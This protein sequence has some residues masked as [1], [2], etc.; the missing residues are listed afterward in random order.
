[1]TAHANTRIDFK[2]LRRKYDLVD[3]VRD[4][5]VALTQ[6]G[7]EWRACCPIHGETHPSFTLFPGS[8]SWVFKCFGCGRKG[9][10][11][12]FVAAMENVEASEAV[13]ILT[14]DAGNAG[15][16]FKPAA[17]PY[18]KPKVKQWTPILPVPEDAP[19]PAGPEDFGF[20][21]HRTYRTPVAVWPYLDAQG[22][23]LGYVCRFQKVDQQTG[24]VIGK[25]VL[26]FTFG[27][28]E[29]SPRP[30]WSWKAF[31]EPRPL[32]GLQRL[33]ARPNAQVLLVEGEKTADAAQRLLPGVVAVSWPGGGKAIAKADWTPLV[34]RKVCIWPDADSH[35]YTQADGPDKAGKMRPLDEQAG[36]MTA[37]KIALTLRAMSAPEGPAPYIK[38]VRLPDPREPQ[39]PADG[40]DLADAESEG[41]DTKRVTDYLKAH[42]ADAWELAAP[43]PATQH[44]SAP[45][46]ASAT[47]PQATQPEQRE[48][49]PTS[50]MDYAQGGGDYGQTMDA[51]D[52]ED[53]FALPFQCL[54]YSEGH[55]CFL[56]DAGTVE[57]ISAASMK[58]PTMFN[59]APYSWWLMNY[60]AKNG[61]A[62]VE[63]AD[64]LVKRSKVV[65][66][67]DPCRIRGRGA[68]EDAGRSVV[69]MGDHLIV[70]GLPVP[71]QT[72]KSRFIYV[73]RP[74]DGTV[75][76]APASSQDAHK[77]VQLCDMLSWERPIF[78]K[79]LAGWCAVAHVCG[80]LRW[81][82]HIWITG[83]SGSGKSS[84]YDNILRAALSGF[85]L[86]CQ[87][88]STE[89]G[90][91]QSLGSDAL[92][93]IF[94]E[95]ESD[96]MK[97]RER[98]RAIL[99]LARQASSEN[100]AAILKG[101]ANGNAQE[102]RIRSCFAFSSIV[103]AAEQ[104]ADVSRITVL[105]LRR[106]TAPDAEERFRKISGAWAELMTPAFAAG[107]RARCIR[108]IP[109]ILE[110]A[111]TF[112]QAVAVHLGSR[113]Y[114]DQVGALLAGAYA[115]HSDRAISLEDAKSWVAAQDWEQSQERPED[116]DE[117]RLLL[118]LL[119]QPVAIDP[120][121]GSGAPIRR[122]VGEV[123]RA[124][125]TGTA[126]P[127]WELDAGHDALGRMGIRMAP[128]KQTAQLCLVVS[129]SH[130]TLKRALESTPW[131]TGWG[132]LLARI[133]GADKLGTFRF[134][135]ATT[136]AVRIPIEATQLAEGQQE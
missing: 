29:G 82:P 110:N 77:L 48:D 2:E 126:E 106:Y 121:G 118:H 64:A 35:C 23:L 42:V 16:S 75:L 50:E 78:G 22:Q 84:V 32:Y 15:R 54:G 12:D 129:E 114:G 89:A 7:R 51:P 88:A 68:W 132:R 19:R 39:A 67:F 111:E 124:L 61:V 113:R 133:K 11:V 135:G 33:A 10:V 125:M 65:G 21:F 28:Y 122:L 131:A 66:P 52:D 43:E 98:M 136:R 17:K 36:T 105:T 62:W 13:R 74:A 102:F 58:G 108:L 79:F 115:L 93:V 120:K 44:T 134:T 83:P 37:L 25:D 49:A 100:G 20:F 3:V 90:I 26:P 95:A 94:D 59:L 70:D 87:S 117:F 127:T 60:P 81:R 101:T 24:E 91:R 46:P 130:A 128:N 73:R 45:A 56:S 69:H 96:N 97:G 4:Y 72:F 57:A 116:G 71:I 9:D 119:Q 5:G 109:I 107:L 8:D 18:V 104:K 76:P 103:V 99:E 123:C 41:W 31:A 34:G 55:H 80:A 112:A 38:I 86:P 53:P 40:W 47:E 14:G 63:A 1:M 6:E 30:C 27:Q 92:P 85:A